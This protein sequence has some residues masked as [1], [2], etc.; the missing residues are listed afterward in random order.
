MKIHG[1]E[2]LAAGDG[3]ARTYACMVGCPY[4]R[5]SPSPRQPAPA[6]E[7]LSL[8][9]LARLASQYAELEEATMRADSSLRRRL[10]LRAGHDPDAAGEQGGGRGVD[11]SHDPG[12][13]YLQV[14]GQRGRHWCSFHNAFISLCKLYR[15]VC[16]N[17]TGCGGG[18][19]RV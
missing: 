6:P 14:R 5:V 17:R 7:H 11:L 15:D 13:R 2:A 1:T 9:D 10:L 12:L 8:E 19:N 18:G 3:E 16:I 4:G